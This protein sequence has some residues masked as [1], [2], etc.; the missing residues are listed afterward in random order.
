MENKTCGECLYYDEPMCDYHA[1]KVV[2]TRKSC[3]LFDPKTPPI[4]NGDRIRQMSN[5]ELVKLLGCTRRLAN[6]IHLED[7]YPCEQCALDYLN[8]PAESEEI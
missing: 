6:C 7:D 8:A 3:K 1:M 5:E 2:S 4:T